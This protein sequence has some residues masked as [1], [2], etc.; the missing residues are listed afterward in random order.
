MKH[1][2]NIITLVKNKRGVY[3]IDIS[4]GCSSGILDNNKG[5]YNECYAAKNAKIR[6]YDFSK[7]IFRYFENDKHKHDIKNQIS[8]IDMPFVRI[9]VSG[10]PSENWEHA[11][12]V[13]EWI[14]KI[15]QLNLFYDEIKDIVIITK[16]WNNLTQLQLNRLIKLKLTIN[17]SI[18]ALDKNEH[19]KNR[20]I[21]Y[22]KLKKYCNSVLRI[23]SCDFNLT[24]KQ[25]LNYNK[26]QDRLFDNEKI[27][28]TVLRVSK[29]NELVLNGIINITK[30]KFLNSIAYFSIKNKNSFIG[31]CL[32][33]PDMC[34]INL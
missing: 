25:S 16:H 26:I 32:I 28:D 13:C 7:T 30:M 9:G 4:K 11:I 15:E 8:N 5:C 27:I 24:N 34:G 21:Q 29:N 20:L 1:Y 33:C 18:S 19:I 2:N 12:N 22:N 10:D 31:K 23:V 17:T 3:D 6:G 14:Q